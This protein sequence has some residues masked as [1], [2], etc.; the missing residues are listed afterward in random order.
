[1][2]TNLENYEF[3]CLRFPILVQWKKLVTNI[4]YSMRLLGGATS[5]TVYGHFLV[6]YAWAPCRSNWYRLL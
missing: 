2:Y 1:M 6:N 4:T 3:E 5:V